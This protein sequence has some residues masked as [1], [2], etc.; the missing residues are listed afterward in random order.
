MT[1]RRQ[2][3]LRVQR[4]G[5]V[6]LCDLLAQSPEPCR[7]APTVVDVPADE[8]AGPDEPLPLPH[9]PVE[10]DVVQMMATYVRPG[11]RD[12][13]ERREHLAAVGVAKVR[14]MRR[15]MRKGP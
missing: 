5:R 4:R 10:H 3:G 13:R 11:D 7:S 2:G 12:M 14:R 6:S 1:K 15:A 9:T 8:I